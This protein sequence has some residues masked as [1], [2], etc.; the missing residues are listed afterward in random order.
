MTRWYAALAF[1][2]IAAST[3]ALQPRAGAAPPSELRVGE[4]LPVTLEPGVRLGFRVRDPKA[5][6]TYSFP[7][8]LGA[9]APAH[10]ERFP[11]AVSG[12]AEEW[13][14]KTIRVGGLCLLAPIA[15]YGLRPAAF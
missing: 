3:V 9:G 8:S 7:L 5:Q 12:A 6:F 15:H 13:L 14:L 2:P 11:V 4:R 10:G 1:L